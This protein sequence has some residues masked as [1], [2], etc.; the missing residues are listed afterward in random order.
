M[1]RKYVFCVKKLH[2]SY[3]FNISHL[4]AATITLLVLLQL[5]LNP[6]S[7]GNTFA[8]GTL[9]MN[10]HDAPIVFQATC[11]PGISLEYNN[12]TRWTNLYKRFGFWYGIQSW[13]CNKSARFCGRFNPWGGEISLGDRG[14]LILKFQNNKIAYK[15]ID[16]TITD[17][18]GFAFTIALFFL[19]D[20]GFFSEFKLSAELHDWDWL[21]RGEK[22]N[23]SWINDVKVYEES[24][25]P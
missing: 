21:Q 2:V 23:N 4:F 3:G 19:F 10:E 6:N 24:M 18:I 17:L 7:M 9:L 20:H 13:P 15:K 1:P 8:S 22:Y 25:M 5:R 14:H 12:Q 11:D 16:R